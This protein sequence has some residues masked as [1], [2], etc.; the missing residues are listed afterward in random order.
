MTR[1]IYEIDRKFL[2]CLFFTILSIKTWSVL[3]THE[4]VLKAHENIL[5][6]HEK[7]LNML[8]FFRVLNSVNSAR[9]RI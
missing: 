1:S 5:I 2:I 8:E 9:K 6:K 4:K 7:V 3:I